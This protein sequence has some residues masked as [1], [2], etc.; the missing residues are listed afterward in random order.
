[1]NMIFSTE[2]VVF[3]KSKFSVAFF[4]FPKEKIIMKCFWFVELSQIFCFES[5]LGI[6]L[7]G[8]MVQPHDSYSSGASCSKSQL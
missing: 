6:K 8:P 1:M 2:N 5:K 7:Y 4:D 3:E